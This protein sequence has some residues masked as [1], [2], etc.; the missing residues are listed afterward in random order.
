MQLSAFVFLSNRVNYV[1]YRQLHLLGV[2]AVHLLALLLVL[3]CVSSVQD[4]DSDDDITSD[5][6]TAADDDSLTMADL[7]GDGWTTEE[8]DCD[9][10]DPLVHPG[11]METPCDGVDNDCDPGTTDSVDADGDEW[12]NCLDCDDTDAS[13]NPGAAELCDGIDNDCDSLMLPGEGED[14]DIDGWMGCEDCDDLDP[15]VH[16]GA[17]EVCN[18]LDDDCDPATDENLDGDGDLQTLCDGDCDDTSPSI[19]SGA[20][21]LCDGID[22]DCDG[23]VPP[24]ELTDADG[25][26]SPQCEDCNEDDP[27]IH[28]Q[29]LETCNDVVDSNCDGDDNGCVMSLSN[30]DAILY[31]ENEND[32]LGSSLS[33][34]RDSDGDGSNEL[35]IGAV[36]Q[37]QPYVT[38]GAVYIVN[39]PLYGDMVIS[40]HLS[41][42]VGHQ[43]H[44][45]AGTAVDTRT[46]LDG[47]GTDDLLVSAALVD[48]NNDINSGVFAFS[49]PFVGQGSLTDAQSEFTAEQNSYFGYAIS[50]SSDLNGDG[51]SDILVGSPDF[52]GM[53]IVHAF[54]G[55]FPGS[56]DDDDANITF[57][58]AA[59]QPGA[60]LGSVLDS[61][62]D[63]NGDGL[64][65]VLI[66]VAY[67]DDNGPNS[68]TAFLSLSPFEETEYLDLDSIALH[69]EHGAGVGNTLGDLAGTSVSFAGD[70]N[71]DGYDDIL[72]GAPGYPAFL[73]DWLGA[74]YLNHGPLPQAGNLSNSD[75][76]ILGE[77]FGDNSG[78]SVSSAG[79]VNGDGFGDILIGAS[80]DD[81]G[82]SGAGAVYLLYGPVDGGTSGDFNLASAD[83]KFHGTHDNDGVEL[84]TGAGD[85]DG[86]GFDD[87]VVGARHNDV[88]CSGCGAV[89]IIYGEG[90]W[91]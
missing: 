44:A 14:I 81:T 60:L 64:Q 65:D 33:P 18:G 23:L 91:Q 21:E 83:A 48:Y 87:I 78:G 76:R 89:Y 8:G 61:S 74:T 31:G 71:A 62:G 39:G 28:P 51:H 32:A 30:A 10:Q 1:K 70:V 59:N 73:N 4:H 67:M 35:A 82:A 79:D 49:L 12:S 72:I 9:D 75:V 34:L 57:E 56:V 11:A 63:V 37:N 22:N 26:G 27:S 42:I 85:F 19:F 68:G 13:V 15:D 88:W 17:P 2:G 41:K 40:N 50:T 54:F 58:L 80:G 53:G 52:Q 6:D 25:D 43:S 5:D 77:H 29:A 38:A 86:D 36:Y 46:D 7:D 66:G 84:A 24:A 47:D 90:L 16:P 20:E 3:G 69:G 45:Y 55:P